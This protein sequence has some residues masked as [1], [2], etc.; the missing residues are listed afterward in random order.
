MTEDYYHDDHESSFSHAD[1]YRNTMPLL[2]VFQRHLQKSRESKAST[3]VESM[4]HLVNSWR[5]RMVRC[6]FFIPLYSFI[7][8]NVYHLFH[9]GGFHKTYTGTQFFATVF[10]LLFLSIS[11]VIITYFFLKGQSTTA[12]TLCINFI[13]Y[14]V[15]TIFL[16]VTTPALV[17]IAACET[18]L[19]Y[20]GKFTTILVDW[21]EKQQD[22]SCMY[23]WVALCSGDTKEVGSSGPDTYEVDN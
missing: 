16:L 6:L 5:G 12:I 18:K 10:Y 3:A 23:L 15:Y 9:N 14:K 13:W 20:C 21:T 7:I 1:G 11:L 8:F 19:T 17:V 4:M 2:Q 22:D